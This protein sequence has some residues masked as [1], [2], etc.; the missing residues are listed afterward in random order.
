MVK[1][2]ILGHVNVDPDAPILWLYGSAGAGKSCVARSIA[3]W[4]EEEGLLLA[5]FFFFRSDSTRN[6]IRHFIPTVAYNITQTIPSTLSS[7]ALAVE[8]DPHIFSKS[9]D[10]QFR[11]LVLEPLS[12]APR[13]NNSR[14][15]VLIID[16]L[17]ECLKEDEQKAILRLFAKDRH[18][19]MKVLVASRPEQA[20]RTSF[21]DT[22]MQRLHTRVDLGTYIAHE[23]VGLF[24]V[25]KF[26]GIIVGR[27]SSQITGL[28]IKTLSFLT[29]MAM[30]MI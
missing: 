21:D 7:I 25:D 15:S 13:S 2:W 23:D 1:R 16:G 26:A 11:R 20:I 27:P 4:C 8:S 19:G 12:S 5:S 3:E 24:L 17:D 14:A 9:L 6:N 28:P 10:V 29:M 18:L 22:P 30:L